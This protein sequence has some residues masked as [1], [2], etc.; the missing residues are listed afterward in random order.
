MTN[1]IAKYRDREGDVWDKNADGTGICS[2][3]FEGEPTERTLAKSWDEVDEMY[4]PLELLEAFISENEDPEYLTVDDF[5]ALMAALFDNMSGQAYS[6]AEEFKDPIRREV[7]H[8]VSMFLH[9]A[10][11]DLRGTDD[12]DT[13]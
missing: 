8:E 9:R 10:A 2:F 13:D 5:A 4:G 11:E 1:P 12:D 6:R 7:N 3:F